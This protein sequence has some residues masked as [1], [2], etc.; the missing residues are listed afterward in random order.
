VN[1]VWVDRI[2][3]LPGGRMQ[4]RLRDTPEPILISLR[5]AQVLNRKL[6]ALRG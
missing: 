6:K 4:I 1:L 5:R 2:E 3:R